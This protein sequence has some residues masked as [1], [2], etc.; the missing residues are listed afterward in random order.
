MGPGTHVCTHPRSHTCALCTPLVGHREPV[1]RD[2]DT[3]TLVI[4]EG[5]EEWQCWGRREAAMGSIPEALLWLRRGPQAMSQGS[6]QWVGWGRGGSTSR[7]PTVCPAV[8]RSCICESW[9][10]QLP[11]G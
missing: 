6:A 2:G 7:G 5:T 3:A 11:K 10:P 9:N 8:H 1:F 4:S